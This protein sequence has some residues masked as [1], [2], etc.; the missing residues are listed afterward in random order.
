MTRRTFKPVPV[1]A[2]LLMAGCK[3]VP[4]EE[5]AAE[6]AVTVV[7]TSDVTT[8]DK[9]PATIRGRQDVEIYPQVS[10]RITAVRVTE[11]Q[12]VNKGQTLFIIDQVPYQAALQTANANA[13]AARA[14]VATARLNYEGKQALYDNQVTSRFDLQKAENALLSA[15]AA[16]EQ[17]Q[18][19]VT[20]ARNN[21]SYTVVS[22]PCD[23]VVGTI[24]YRVGTLVS[25]SSASPLTTVSDNNEMYVY[26]SIPENR[27]ISLIRKYGSADKALAAMPDVCLF[28]NDGSR[29]EHD[30]RIE[31]ISG[32]LDAE[33]GS[34]SLRA[35]FRN[36]NG[37]L[38][39]GG[40]GNIGL[41][42]RKENV[43]TIPQSATYELQDKVYAY[44]VVDGKAVATVIK[45]QALNEQKLYVVE[46]GLAPG[47]TIVA[48]GVGLLQDGSPITVKKGG[49]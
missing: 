38:H 46:S 27:M 22:S 34:V 8:I 25:P 44:K 32:V 18:A 21:L 24:P 3:G 36:E 23:G 12:H 16:L 13:T 9:Y 19:G 7:A 17:A 6:Y 14:E 15:E 42:E 33:T 35:A 41:V 29:Y 5:K 43:L 10:G 37:L 26:F 39:S 28:I 49:A 48:E 4:M 1:I 31:S 2:A 11:G 45:V 40:A 47:D 20:D 30:G